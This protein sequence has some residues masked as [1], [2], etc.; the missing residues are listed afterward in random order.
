M[1]YNDGTSF[2]RALED[3][4]RTQSIQTGIPLV[5]LRKLVAF[6]RFLARLLFAYPNE[7][8]LKGGLAIQLRIGDRART[9]KDID[10]LALFQ[11]PD[12]RDRLIFVGSRDLGDWFQFEIEQ[13]RNDLPVVHRGLRFHLHS[14]LNGRVFEDFHLDIG[15]GDPVLAP[16]EYFSTPPLLGFA[17]IPATVI[18]CYPATQQIAEKVHALTML[19]PSGESSRVKDLVDILLLAERS[20][21]NSELLCQAIQATFDARNT[22]PLPDH[23]SALPVAWVI[24][25]RKLSGE[26]GLK[27][28]SLD[29]ATAALE[30]FLNPVLNKRFGGKWIP[31][32]WQWDVT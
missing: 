7:W 10:I 19:H 13:A 1:K 16:V 4:L 26:V 12:L 11:E 25:F 3:R 6:D 15:I 23:L 20:E 17:E 27:Y 31:Q 8:I 18:P 2:R 29:D 5:R 32:K 24:P 28:A 14:L 30:L 21:M 22:H 9:T